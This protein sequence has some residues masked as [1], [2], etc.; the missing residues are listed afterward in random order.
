MTTYELQIDSIGRVEAIYEDRSNKGRRIFGRTAN[1]MHVQ[2]WAEELPF[3]AA[4]LEQTNA[5]TFEFEAHNVRIYAITPE[6]REA[7]LAALAAKVE[8][9]EPRSRDPR[10]AIALISY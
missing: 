10:T 7:V 9:E 8:A 4:A 3:D 2:L 1:G 5:N 6:Q